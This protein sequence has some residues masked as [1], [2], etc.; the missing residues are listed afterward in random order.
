GPAT[1]RRGAAGRAS[2]P[3]D[4]ALQ[5]FRQEAAE[6]WDHRRTVGAAVREST[7]RRAR[8]GLVPLVQ[9]AAGASSVADDERVVPWR[10]QRTTEEIEAGIDAFLD[11][12]LRSSG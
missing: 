10:K 11:N 7:A 8:G 12:A 6:L 4:R 2:S 3:E 1:R 9:P 5:Q